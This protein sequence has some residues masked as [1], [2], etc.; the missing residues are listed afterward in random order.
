M[1]D[2]QPSV[3]S[4]GFGD[5]IS[6]L[7]QFLSLCLC[8]F[9]YCFKIRGKPS[10]VPRLQLFI[11]NYG[12]ALQEGCSGS[13]LHNGSFPLSPLLSRFQGREMRQPSTA[14]WIRWLLCLLAFLTPSTPTSRHLLPI[15]PCWGRGPLLCSVGGSAEAW[16]PPTGCQ[17]HPLP[18]GR[19]SDVSRP[20]PA[21]PPVEKHLLGQRRD[22]LR[23][24]GVR[25]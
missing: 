10:K 20:C 4:I 17:Q 3:R 12:I 25:H 11:S 23:A 18:V 24:M 16:P 14:S 19:T 22:T 5:K 13:C 6:F 8:N 15:I 9:F 2:P 7:Q 1:A 21:Q